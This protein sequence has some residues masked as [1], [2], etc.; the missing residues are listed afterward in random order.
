MLITGLVITLHTLITAI[1]FY[2][3]LDNKF[4]IA[5]LLLV[6]IQIGILILSF[7]PVEVL[8]RKKFDRIS[9]LK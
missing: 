4:S 1:C 8:L 6:D 7:I 9:N 5:Y 3:T 2:E